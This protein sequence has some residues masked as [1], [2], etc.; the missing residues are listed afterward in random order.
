MIFYIYEDEV[1]FETRHFCIGL[2]VTKRNAKKQ[3]SLLF[4][5]S[6]FDTNTNVN[7]NIIDRD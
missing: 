4:L 6:D 3:D 2:E 7:I 5:T 1:R